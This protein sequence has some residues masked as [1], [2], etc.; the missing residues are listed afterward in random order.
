[1]GNFDAETGSLSEEMGLTEKDLETD[2]TL[3]EKQV[4]KGGQEQKEESQESSKEK[5]ADPE[6]IRDLSEKFM[7]EKGESIDNWIGGDPD[8]ATEAH[9]FLFQAALE[10]E[11]SN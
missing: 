4:D 9:R 3:A 8:Q 11:D 7:G 1:M 2:R 10:E 5:M 6:L